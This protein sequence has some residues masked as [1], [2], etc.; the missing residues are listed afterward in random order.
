MQDEIL[1]R[2]LERE[3]SA[4]R[5]AE[6]LLEQK[7]L[8]LFIEAQ[9]RQATLSRLEE[10]EARYRLIV[11]M[12][13]DAILV[14]IDGHIAF[15]NSA[16]RRM[17]AA[18]AS[19][20]LVGLALPQLGIEGYITEIT[21]DPGERIELLAT[22]CDGSSID[23]E[24]R[25]MPMVYDGKSAL[26]VVARDISD[27]K[28][29]EQQLA[30]QATHDTLT[31]VSNRS[32]LMA[33]LDDVLAYAQRQ[34]LPFWVAFLDLDRFKYINDRFGHQAGD[35]LLETITA[36]LRQLLRKEDIIGRYGGDEFILVLRGGSDSQLNPQLL[37]RILQ[38]VC[39]PIDIDGH[40][41]QVT[42]SLGISTFP[43]DGYSS[44]MLLAKADA[45]MY[46]AKESG[47][48]GYQLYDKD[49]HARIVE[50]Q[51]ID[52]HLADALSNKEFFLLYQP[53]VEIATGKVVGVEALLRWR[54]PL[55][56]VLTPDRFISSAEKSTLINSIGAWVLNEACHQCAAWHREGLSPLSVSVNLSA[57]QLNGPELVR[58]VGDA[59]A[60][61]GL[62]PSSLEL[63]LTESMMMADAEQTLST[64]RA[65]HE[66]GVRVA[67]D[68]FGTGYSSF[69]YLNRLP[70]SCLKIDRQFVTGLDGP[71]ARDASMITRTLIQLAH[72]LGLYVVAEGVET[73]QQLQV[74]R[75]QGCDQVQGW[76]H[77]RPMDPAA[78][79]A[80][81]AG[82]DA[83]AWLTDNWE[84]PQGGYA[85][86]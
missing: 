17:F 26:Q 22:K 33:L 11:E 29:L 2:K 67:V 80:S 71:G 42:C 41:L 39:E 38:V 25:C 21:K 82:Y 70:L 23:I 50:R 62:P 28:R 47:R 54:H 32:A 8:E 20:G 60:A 5:Q 35:H 83:A 53:K 57:R 44:N 81:L 73:R 36:R 31:G 84:Q 45:A 72:S 55:L 24:L 4:R 6:T 9:E 75:D 12:S 86:V 69:T 43:A 14:D 1:Q 34:K 48:N 76:L 16:A 3:I 51:Q 58:L 7:S 85:D 63:E 68:D 59:L 65:L 56:G 66:Q 15:A 77:S 74:L 52:H 30:Y 18:T 10:S 49:I 46:R 37:E 78:L 64:L 27:R 19:T 40:S 79:A 13:P 61:C